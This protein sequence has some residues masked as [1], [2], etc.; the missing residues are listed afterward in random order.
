[1]DCLLLFLCRSRPLQI[2]M[3]ATVGLLIA[4][5]LEAIH[6]SGCTMHTNVSLNVSSSLAKYAGVA[7][8]DACCSLCP[9]LPRCMAFTVRNDTCFLMDDLAYSTDTPGAMTGH[10][11]NAHTHYSDPSKGCLPDEGNR[12]LC[13][14][15]S[16]HILLFSVQFCRALVPARCAF[17]DFCRACVH[18]S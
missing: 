11:V 4:G 16:W 18:D 10:L 12:Q 17:R 7:S 15:C 2:L 13:Q 5:A 6:I 8:L 3:I 1:M 14:C 9:T